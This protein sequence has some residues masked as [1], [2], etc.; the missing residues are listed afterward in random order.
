MTKIEKWLRRKQ[1]A[2]NTDVDEGWN[3][4]GEGAKDFKMVCD[5]IPK[6]EKEAV[7]NFIEF[8]FSDDLCSIDEELEDK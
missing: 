7:E 4:N 3:D 2:W 6:L 5:F 1:K 8:A